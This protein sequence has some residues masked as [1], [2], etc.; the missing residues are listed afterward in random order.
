MDLQRILIENGSTSEFL[1]IDR[2]A[3]SW[4]KRPDIELPHESP[5]AAPD[6]VMLR[7]GILVLLTIGLSVIFGVNGGHP[8]NFMITLSNEEMSCSSCS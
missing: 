2:I 8:E 4:R 1:L 7:P 5:S 6:E 3:W